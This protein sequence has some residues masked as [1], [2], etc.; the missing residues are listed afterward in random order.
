MGVGVLFPLASHGGV[1]TTDFAGLGQGQSTIQASLALTPL[2]NIGGDFNTIGEVRYFGGNFAPSGWLRAEGQTLMIAQNSALFSKL[3]TTYGGDGRTTFV[4]PDL[5]SRT[6]TG[7]GSGAGLTPV[8]LGDQTGTENVQLG[9]N[10][11]ALHNHTLPGGGTT[12]DTGNATPSSYTNLQPG[13]GISYAVT[14][15]GVYPS[16]APGAG[17]LDPTL[18]FVTM[19]A[20]S[21][22]SPGFIKA[23]GQLLPIAGNDALFSLL[24]TIYGGDGRTTFGLPDLKGRTVIGEGTGT[25]LTQQRLGQTSGVESLV[26][27]YSSMG[28]HS[29]GLSPSLDFTDPA[30]LGSAVTNMQ[31]TV[32][33][34]YLVRINGNFPSRGGLTDSGPYLGEIGLFAGNFVPAGWVEADGQLLEI[35]QNSALFSLFG[36]TYGGDG[37]VTFGLPDLRGRLAVGAGQGP[38]LMDWRL[39]QMPG[40]ETNVMVAGQLPSHAHDY[41]VEDAVPAPVPRGL[42]F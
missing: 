12:T 31:P 6:A 25:G 22:L 33:M 37:R 5:R 34:Q 30:G 29:H 26:M 42:S 4:L 36:T 17:S 18:G 32:A 19:S 8:S 2:I 7:T 1:L 24:G 28:T 27:S 20:A 35:S 15:Q 14:A 40:G 41:T 13:L 21:F 10:N 23:E 3:G 16:R 38:G 9:T 39:G 11:L